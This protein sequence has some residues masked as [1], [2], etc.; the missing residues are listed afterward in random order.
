MKVSNGIKIAMANKPLCYKTLFSRTLIS[1][2]ITATCF[3][4]AKI[5]IDD[6]MQSVAFNDFVQFIRTFLRNFVAL[7]DEANVNFASDLRYHIQTILSV[8][9]SRLGEVLFIA[10]GILLLIQVAKFLTSLC[11]YVVAVN[12]NEHM[13]SLRHAKFFSTL[14]EHLKPALAYATYCVISLFLYNTLIITLSIL[15]FVAF[16]HILGFFTVPLV[17]TFI[18][19]ADAFR[20][21][22][23]GMVPAKMV[24]EGCKVTTAFRSAF[25]GLKSRVMVE[26]FISYFTMRIL[27]MVVTAVAGFFTFGVSVIITMPLFSVSYIAVR[28]VD[29]YTVA[30]KKYYITFDNIVV[31]KELRTKGE[32]LL[33]QVDIDV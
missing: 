5:I 17:I 8:V 23:V 6:V 2:I 20:L 30:I 24:C 16:I 14:A 18:L 29:Y 28:F 10:I 3:L 4:V 9:R 25:K 12:V 15:L 27:H 19:F 31:P 26:R 22:L 33:N 7:K 32:Q 13:S 11:D 21:M 1:M